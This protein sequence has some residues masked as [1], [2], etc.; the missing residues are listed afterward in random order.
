MNIDEA[1]AVVDGSNYVHFSDEPGYER[2]VWIDGQF[3]WISRQFTLAPG[4][5]YD[6]AQIMQWLRY[7]TE[8]TDFRKLLMATLVVLRDRIG[9]AK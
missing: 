8:N 4:K 6:E 3:E 5:W 2:L 1:R 7:L 9:R